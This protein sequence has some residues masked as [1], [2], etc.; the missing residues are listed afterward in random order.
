MEKI[1][2]TNSPLLSVKVKIAYSLIY[3]NKKIDVV[4]LSFFNQ[5]KVQVYLIN[6]RIIFK[7]VLVLWNTKVSSIRK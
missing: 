1:V 4:F 5:T 3:G 2:A 6:L 7:V